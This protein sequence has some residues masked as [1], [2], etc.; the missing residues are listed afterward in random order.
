MSMKVRVF[1]P[2][3]FHEHERLPHTI[4]FGCECCHMSRNTK[5]TNH[6]VHHV[7]NGK[8]LKHLTLHAG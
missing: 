7:R 8:L 5:S 6:V 2:R 3:L 1:G 4:Q